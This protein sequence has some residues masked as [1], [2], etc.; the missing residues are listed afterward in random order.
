MCPARCFHVL[1]PK[2][3]ESI[4]LSSRKLVCCTPEHIEA[5]QKLD[6]K[7][8]E[9]E[10]RYVGIFCLNASLSLDGYCALISKISS[11]SHF[12]V[13]LTSG[14][15]PGR[16]QRRILSTETVAKPSLTATFA[17]YATSWRGRRRKGDL[18]TR[19]FAT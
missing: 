17:F 11:I 12:H 4:R 1:Y 9:R 13:L 14:N 2:S 5:L 10:M 19:P 6:A 8:Q 18:T 16:R 7:S 3:L 15:D